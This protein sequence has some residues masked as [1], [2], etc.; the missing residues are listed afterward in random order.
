MAFAAGVCADEAG[1]VVRRMSGGGGWRR[2][3]VGR[4]RGGRAGLIRRAA[5]GRAAGAFSTPGE[6]QCQQ[7]RQ[8][9][10]G[11][12]LSA[13]I[14]MALGV[15]GHGDPVANAELTGVVKRAGLDKFV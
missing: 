2:V 9:Q 15:E 13:G 3:L 7:C 12:G 11:G 10:G 6:E 14:L 4:V 1:R 8:Q 5:C